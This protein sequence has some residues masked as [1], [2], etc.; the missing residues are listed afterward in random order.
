MDV[1]YVLAGVV[2]VGEAL[3]FVL[4]CCSRVRGSEWSS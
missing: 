1:C 2:L 4:W 3:G